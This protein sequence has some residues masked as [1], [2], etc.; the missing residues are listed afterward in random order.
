[1]IENQN[2]DD[3]TRAMRRWEKANPRGT[4]GELNQ[5]IADEGFPPTIYPI[6]ERRE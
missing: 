5:Y 3:R 4:L 2:V 6:H 1:M